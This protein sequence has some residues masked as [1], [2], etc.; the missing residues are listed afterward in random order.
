MVLIVELCCTIIADCPRLTL[1]TP[2]TAIITADLYY[3]LNVSTYDRTPG[4]SVR[5]W[6]RSGLELAGP[7]EVTC[8]RSGY[9]SGNP[10]CKPGNL[11]VHLID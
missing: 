10:Y 7:G 6:C 4:T 1:L 11:Y 9:W 2:D 8:Y 5:V 3:E